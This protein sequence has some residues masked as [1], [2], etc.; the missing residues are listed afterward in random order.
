MAPIVCAP[1][2]DA[3]R[4]LAEQA[5]ARVAELAIPHRESALHDTVSASVGISMGARVSRERVAQLLP[6]A[7]RAAEQAA[8]DGGDRVVV[9]E[10]S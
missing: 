9:V 7:I 1:A 5:R 4:R 2:G 3:A 6:D 10:G 8:A